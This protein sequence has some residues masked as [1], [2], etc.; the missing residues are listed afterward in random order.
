MVGTDSKILLGKNIEYTPVALV[1]DESFT[2]LIENIR[3]GIAGKEWSGEISLTTKNTIVFCRIALTVFDDGC[4]GVSIILEDITNRKL[5]EQKIDE[6]GR[7][8]LLL[9]ENSLDM[10]GRIKPDYT[11]TYASPAYTTT[12]GFLPEEV[13][14]KRGSDFIHPEDVHILGSSHSMGGYTG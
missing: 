7:Q 3:E 10:I 9:A 13:I 8:F 14:G 12:L 5:T 6:S 4:K 2:G 11:H 1:F